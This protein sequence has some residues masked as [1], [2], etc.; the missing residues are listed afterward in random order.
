MCTVIF[1]YHCTL[2]TAL[3]NVLCLWVNFVRKLTWLTLHLKDV[4]IQFAIQRV[5]YLGSICQIYKKLI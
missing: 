3:P 4:A 2:K 1:L 5:S